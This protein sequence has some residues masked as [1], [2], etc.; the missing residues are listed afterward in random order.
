MGRLASPVALFA[1]TMVMWPP[2]KFFFMMVL[3]LYRLFTSTF[4]RSSGVSRI[5]GASRSL[6]K[7]C[8]MSSVGCMTRMGAGA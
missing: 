8:P 2:G 3:P 6:L 5:M 1:P 7:V 4:S